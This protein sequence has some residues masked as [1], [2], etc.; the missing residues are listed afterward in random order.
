MEN[1]AGN[2]KLVFCVPDEGKQVRAQKILRRMAGI[3]N[4]CEGDFPSLKEYND[5]LEDVMDMTTKLIE[6]KDVSAIEEKIHKYE[7]ENAE[8][9]KLRRDQKGNVEPPGGVTSRRP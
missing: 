5:Y 6:G 8:L 1:E 3:F 2:S 4:K 7:N 9:I